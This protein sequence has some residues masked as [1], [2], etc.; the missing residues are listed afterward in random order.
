M[1]ILLIPTLLGA[2]GC[3]AQP[4]DELARCE[5]DG[6]RLVHG[7]TPLPEASVVLSAGDRTAGTTADATGDFSLCF[8]AARGSNAVVYIVAHGA[9]SHR[10]YGVE[11]ASVVGPES[12]LAEVAEAG[13]RVDWHA[14]PELA[15]TPLSTVRYAATVLANGGPRPANHD[16]LLDA[17]RRMTEV[18]GGW[19]M[20]AAATYI[21]LVAEGEIELQRH[22]TTLAWVQDLNGLGDDLATVRGDM[23]RVFEG[24]LD[25]GHIQAD[26]EVAPGRWLLDFASQRSDRIVEGGVALELLP[27]GTATLEESF[28]TLPTSWTP[29]VW[30][31]T[32]RSLQVDLQEPVSRGESTL[33]EAQ[34]VGLAPR[35]L[36]SAIRS[37]LRGADLVVPVELVGLE[38]RWLAGGEQ[39]PLALEYQKRRYRIDLGLA[40][41]GITSPPG[42]VTSSARLNPWHPQTLIPDRA[43]SEADFGQPWVLKL[44]LPARLGHDAGDSQAQ[45]PVRQAAVFVPSA[46]GTGTLSGVDMPASRVTW[47]IRDGHLVLEDDAGELAELQWVDRTRG[48]EYGLMTRWRLE[49]GAWVTTYGGGWQIDGSAT[50]DSATLTLGPS[51]YWQTTIIQ[52]YDP[53]FERHTP[54]TASRFGFSFR[55][56]GALT[57]YNEGT[58]HTHLTYRYEGEA[59]VMEFGWD[60]R[61]DADCQVGTSGC[62]LRTRRTWRPLGMGDGQLYV[63]EHEEIP[64]DAQAYLT[65]A[66]TFDE[67]SGE[68]RDRDGAAY[69]PEELRSRI[70]PRIMAYYPTEFPAP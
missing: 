2:A 38:Y 44:P 16:E 35:E 64:A 33:T 46:D 17:E 58:R 49:D 23:R 51:R 39:I 19:A 20:T 1:W 56:G 7:W 25:S 70:M 9:V 61:I 11:L 63:L 42:N 68:W 69:D 40:A 12:A 36:E 24:F 15:V 29:A 43:L 34:V 5:A 21:Q 31:A 62:V 67:A 27:D 66:F 3:V 28:L 54:P 41:Y 4:I 26:Y 55:S 32:P 30:L 60:A 59:L 14:V 50:L 57:N 13:T 18:L 52:P 10:Q 65:G 53:H 48:G 22:A 47:H 45:D 37:A 6:N 8:D